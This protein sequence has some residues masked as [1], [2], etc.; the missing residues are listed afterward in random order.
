M[1]TT[2]EIRDSVRDLLLEIIRIPSTRGNEGPAMRHLQKAMAP[3]VDYANLV[4]V[5]D[6][7]MSDPDYA[8]PL[9]GFSY[10]DTPNLECFIHGHNNGRKI[11]FNAH[12]DVV[13]PSEGQD[14]AYDPYVEGDLI[15]GRGAC[16]D[17]GPAV[18][19]YAMARMLQERGVKPPG[20]LIF[21]F[22]IEEE[23][24]GNGTLALV[25]RGV[26]ADAAVVLEGSDFAIFPTVRGAVWFELKTFGRAGH[27][28]S[29]A[30]T[31][32]ALKK[33]VQAMDILEGYHDRLL[34]ASRGI[35]LFDVHE[36]PMPI[37]FGQIEAGSWPSMVP[38][39]AT[40]KGVLG[41]LTNK[42][43]HQVQEEMRDAILEEGDE[44]LREN[45]EL[46][47]P[48]LNSDGNKIPEDHPLVQ[49]LVRAVQKHGKEGEL[50]GMT[51]SC[52]AWFYNNMAEIPTVVFGPGSI[53]HAH[54]R[55]EQIKLS[56]I[57]LSAEILLDFIEDF[58]SAEVD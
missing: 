47:F 39:E 5:D 56:D 26:E 35:P 9:P 45:F 13:P 22:V 4:E 38:A 54:T 58:G 57:M 44:W 2:N 42:T 20:D 41:F 17:K 32:S 15:Y 8:F 37:T 30:T 14:R 33:A 25:R 48:M 52:D 40:V 7:I 6:A 1:A 11:V 43:R 24:G 23:N 55:D 18:V 29:A 51:G 27:S 12:I 3:F 10:A 34:E 36:N 21:H 49:A 53:V 46:N 50:R 16:D 28:G 19:M 31:I